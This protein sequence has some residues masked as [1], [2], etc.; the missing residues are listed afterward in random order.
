MRFLLTLSLLVLS[1]L[2]SSLGNRTF[3]WRQL[4]RACCSF[5][6]SCIFSAWDL[7]IL[8]GT[9]IT[10]L[11][12]TFFQRHIILCIYF[13][14]PKPPS[15]R[16]TLPQDINLREIV[17]RRALNFGVFSA[18]NHHL[19]NHYSSNGS[20]EYYFHL[21]VKSSVSESHNTHGISSFSFRVMV[22]LS[23][24]SLTKHNIHR[25]F[26]KLWIMLFGKAFQHLAHLLDLCVPETRVLVYRNTHTLHEHYSVITELYNTK[27]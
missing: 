25:H 20:K 10:S 15:W 2:N 3:S 18:A 16:H 8:T 4:D 14:V 11:V 24:V 13:P 6:T 19:L 7:T 1:N 23:I 27:K 5:K 26:H 12:F 21:L 22:L 9:T 17:R